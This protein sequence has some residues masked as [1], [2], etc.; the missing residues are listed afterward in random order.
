MYQIV[1]TENRKKI[2]TLYNYTRESD[3]NYRFEKLKSQDT[4]F[5]KTKIYRDKKL[6]DVNYEI[7]LIKKR[8]Q[9]DVNRIIKNEL[10]K[11]VEETI[12]DDEWVIIQTS[13]YPV[14]ETFNVSGANRKLTAKEIIDNVVTVNKQKKAPKQILMLNNKIVIEGLDL[15]IVT[16]K[17]ID[18]TIRLYNKIRTYCFDNKIGD[19]VFFGSIP[20]DNRKAWYKKIHERTGIGYNRL[21]RSNSR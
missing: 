3:V 10:G 12:D 6:V 21:Y 19:V 15:F 9:D 11:F 2:K 5:P 1:L 17:D 20:K 7:L 18:E 14:E 8:A 16:C 4:F 13:F